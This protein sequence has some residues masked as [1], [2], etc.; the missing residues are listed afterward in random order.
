M[1]RKHAFGAI[2]EHDASVA[3]ARGATDAHGETT[4]VCRAGIVP[5][6]MNADVA[7]HCATCMLRL[8]SST[9]T[10][11]VLSIPETDYT[12]D[13]IAAGTTNKAI[14]KRLQGTIHARAQ[15][16]HRATAGGQFIE[17]VSGHPRIVQGRILEID[18]AGNRVL[19]QAVV[20]MWVALDPLQETSAFAAG[21]FVN[22]YMESGVT[23]A[24]TA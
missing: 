7:P 18:S 15:K 17:P 23:F 9:G 16:M 5:I 19:L 20:P 3:H 24:P 10:N 8:E 13:L 4:R 11:F 6:L 12:L 14:G 2:R 22:F 1:V 21:D